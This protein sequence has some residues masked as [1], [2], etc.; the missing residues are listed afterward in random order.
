MRDLDFEV[1]TIDFWYNEIMNFVFKKCSAKGVDLD[2]DAD[3]RDFLASA[4][5]KC[6][7]LMWNYEFSNPHEDE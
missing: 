4:F 2:N 1:E 5:S 6:E 3:Y 7:E